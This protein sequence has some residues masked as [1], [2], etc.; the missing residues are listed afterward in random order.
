MYWSARQ[1][2]AIATIRSLPLLCVGMDDGILQYSLQNAFHL[3]EC[4][5]CLIYGLWLMYTIIYCRLSALNAGCM[6]KYNQH[7]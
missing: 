5:Y 4:K 3:Y 7:Y 6:L 1:C 2:A